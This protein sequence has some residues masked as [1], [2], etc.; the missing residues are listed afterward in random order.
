MKF[1]IGDPVR[2]IARTCSYFDQTGTVAAVS[3]HQDFAFHVTGPEPWPLWFGPHGAHPR[4][5]TQAGGSVTA[6]GVAPEDVKWPLQLRDKVRILSDPERNGAY[7]GRTGT[8][9]S[10]ELDG[11][12][13]VHL[14]MNYANFRTS[15][16]ERVK[17]TSMSGAIKYDRPQLPPIKEAGMLPVESVNHPPH[18]G[19]EDDPYEVIK[20]A[21]AW[22]FDKDAYLFNVLKYIGRAD[23]KGATLEDHKKA[24][25]YLDRKIK[26]LEAGQ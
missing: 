25:F 7:A 9:A 18:Y 17:E 26:Q 4:R 12:V 1:K 6:P 11:I 5:S 16:L 10:N 14:G 2:I 19:G 21:E 8:I 15:D 3:E 23:K 13:Y 20:V 22:G 24:R